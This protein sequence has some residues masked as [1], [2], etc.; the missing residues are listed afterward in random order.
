MAS[1]GGKCHFT[2]NLVLLLS[3]SSI[4][5]FF[6]FS[7]SL[8]LLQAQNYP[9]SRNSHFGFGPGS[10]T[11]YFGYQCPSYVNPGH[12]TH[13]RESSS[14]HQLPDAY[15]T[16]KHYFRLILIT[17]FTPGLLSFF[18]NSPRFTLKIRRGNF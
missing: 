11:F 7:S 15:R 9:R 10:F 12:S 3:L 16:R 18:Q 17:L 8:R 6:N 13:S 4:L 2:S 1:L 14:V 5:P